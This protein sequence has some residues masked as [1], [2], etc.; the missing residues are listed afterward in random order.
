MT[1]ARMLVPV[2]VLAACAKGASRE[3]PAVLKP[4]ECGPPPSVTPASDGTRFLAELPPLPDGV[5]CLEHPLRSLR[6]VS[7]VHRDA[8]H[9]FVPGEHSGV[10]FPAPVGTP[11][12]AA[13]DGTVTSI[14]LVVP[15][16]D[17]YV[18]IR[19]AEGWLIS[20]H[21]LSRVDVTLGQTVTRGMTVGLTGGA[22]CA[23]G[24]GPWT[25]GP[26][27]HVGLWVNGASADPLPAFCP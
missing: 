4:R 5:A 9:P 21:H 3:P 2:I 8:H 24:S 13:A 17:A 26:H 20:V 14:G 18:G 15:G 10:D 22:V 11:V 7:S 16:Q 6:R 1:A 12:R 25:T 23:P 19:F 27:L